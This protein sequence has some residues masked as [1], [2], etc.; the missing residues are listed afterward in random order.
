MVW[1]LQNSMNLRKV[2]KI[3]T[4]TSIFMLISFLEIMAQDAQSSQ[5]Y[6]MP[7]HLNPAYTGSSE[8]SNAYFNSR[9]QYPEISYPFTSMRFAIDYSFYKIPSG[10]G[11]IMSREKTGAGNLS[12][13]S[14]GGLYSYYFKVNRDWELR[15]GVKA[16]AIFQN[17]DFGNYIFGDQ[18]SDNGSFQGS[19]Q[20][21]LS[22]GESI[23]YPDIQLG[24]LIQNDA[25]WFGISV[26]HITEPDQS[27]FSGESKLPRNYSIH[28][29]YKFGFIN[30][31]GR[32]LKQLKEFSITPMALFW[33]QGA[34]KR[35][36]LGTHFVYEPLMIGF[37]Y[38]GIPIGNNE[39]GFLNQDAVVFLLG[40]Y[41]SSFTLGYSYD[42]T[43]SPL[44]TSAGG[45]HEITFSIDFGFYAMGTKKS[46]RKRWPN[47]RL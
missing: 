42:Y 12:K 2:I 33:M 34:F 19:S 17:T 39:A 44:G 4:G 6:S 22:N 10:V 38:R 30:A 11:L 46:Y 21:N 31:N 9:I 16:A 41:T 20:E 5:L 26:D 45:A 24:A 29:G 40:F 8:F 47:P 7:M 43:I 15:T 1:D 18:I 25:A 37:W 23:I 3:L 27:Y 35:L 13:T 32:V 14:I 36:E 28:G